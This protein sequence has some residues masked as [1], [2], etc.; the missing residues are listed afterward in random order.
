MDLFHKTT[1]CEVSDEICTIH[2]PYTKKVKHTR[3]ADTC[4]IVGDLVITGIDEKNLSKNCLVKVS[5]E[6]K[7]VP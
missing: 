6:E 5:V 7:T 1:K 2:D 4:V 3:P